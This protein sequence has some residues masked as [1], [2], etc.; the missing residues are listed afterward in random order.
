[1]QVAERTNSKINAEIR[2]SLSRKR[3]TIS[4]HTT[5]L[6]RKKVFSHQDF[7]VL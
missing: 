5:L 4:L 1:M 2:D 3:I 6:K 7:M